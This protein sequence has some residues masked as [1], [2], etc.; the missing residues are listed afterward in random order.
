MANTQKIE[1]TQERL[2][3]ELRH[4]FKGWMSKIVTDLS[5]ESFEREIA[6]LQSDQVYS[7]FGLDCPEYALVRVMGRVSISIGRRLGEIY[8]KMPRFIAQARFNLTAIQ[9]APVIDDRLQL[10]V[11]I[12]YDQ[13]TEEDRAHAIEVVRKHVNPKEEAEAAA[14]EIR[15][16]FNPNDSARLRKDVEM[17]ALLKKAKMTPIYLIFS[18]ISPRDEAIARLERAGWTFLIGEKATAFMNDLI[19]MDINKIL[20]DPAV[21]EEVKREVGA[22]MKTLY[23]SSTV[24][25][26]V[27]IHS[28]ENKEER[29]IKKKDYPRRT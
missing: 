15:Y 29:Q 5:K 26:T 27:G 14:I 25:E 12:P 6:N 1:T 22:I 2:L 18:T 16:N 28:E 4:H 20:E 17:A 13:L 21:K 7:S 23:S 8:D 3:R 19:G 9:V 24:R 11:C 10:D